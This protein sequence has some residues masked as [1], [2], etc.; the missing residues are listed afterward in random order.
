MQKS[1]LFILVMLLSCLGLSAQSAG[2][3][4][5]LSDFGTNPGQLNGYLYTPAKPV[6]GRP[7]VIALHGCG[8]DAT[9]FARLTGWNKLAD[10]E[11]FAVLYP[12][13]SAANNAQ[14]CFNW[15][16]AADVAADGGELGS[17][18]QMARYAG[19]TLGLDTT[20]YYATGFSAGG[21]MTAAL[22][23]A[24]PSA[25]RAGAP[26][27]GIAAGSAEDL[28]AALSIMR[29]KAS[30][31]GAEWASR[32]EEKNPGFGG[33]WPDMLIIQGM[34]DSVVRPANGLELVK[35]WTALH[36]IDAE[37]APLDGGA[38]DEAPHV[39]ALR[40]RSP[41]GLAPVLWYK[42]YDWPHAYPI[43]PGAA[44]QQG[45]ETDLWTKDAD[46]HA[47]HYIARFFRLR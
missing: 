41:N 2:H 33:P 4:Q 43:D 44:P 30:L 34:A 29:G 42:L 12:E 45:G 6:A 18:M 27:A 28:M 35:Q 1:P 32:V 11:G 21:A 31:S 9:A 22:L 13:Q 26:V 47:T 20:R 15:F 7:L 3:W 25:F 40:F 23:A 14:K 37:R 39:T 5:S 16:Q 8:Q 36:G 46:W 24:Y 19:R 10:E 38:L 17:I